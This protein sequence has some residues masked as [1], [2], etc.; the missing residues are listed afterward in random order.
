[1]IYT[2]NQ[3]YIYTTKDGGIKLKKKLS[4]KQWMVLWQECQWISEK[5][6]TVGLMFKIKGL[7]KYGIADW[8]FYKQDISKIITTFQAKYYYAKKKELLGL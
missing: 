2:E 5:K 1:M 6:K 7:F 4:S 3:L 8:N